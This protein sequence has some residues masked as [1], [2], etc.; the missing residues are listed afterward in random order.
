MRMVCGMRSPFNAALRINLTIYS[1]NGTNPGV[2]ECYSCASMK[3]INRE[4]GSFGSHAFQ[5]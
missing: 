1:G 3:I 4:E 2:P 5:R